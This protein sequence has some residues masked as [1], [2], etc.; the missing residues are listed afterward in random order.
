[1]RRR[2]VARMTES[3]SMAGESATLASRIRGR[4][5]GESGEKKNKDKE[6]GWHC[7]VHV[8]HWG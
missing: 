7:A 8:S 3:R 2:E 1:M 4:V 5:T 6:D